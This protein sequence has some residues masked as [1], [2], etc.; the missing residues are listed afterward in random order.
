MVA[1]EVPQ[2]GMPGVGVMGM[3]T[4]SELTWVLLGGGVERVAILGFL[5]HLRD[6]MATWGTLSPVGT[7]R[8]GACG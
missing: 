7:F 5:L 1:A 6:I 3:G 4:L 2:V 8:L